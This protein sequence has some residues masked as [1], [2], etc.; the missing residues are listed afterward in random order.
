[1]ASA[2]P[3]RNAVEQGIRDMRAR[4]EA[5]GPAPHPAIAAERE[6]TLALTSAAMGY[7]GDCR[8]KRISDDDFGGGFTTALGN[9]IASI[10][11]TL[12]RG[13]T[14][15]ATMLVGTF[16]RGAF[17]QAMRRVLNQDPADWNEV[18]VATPEP[19]PNRERDMDWGW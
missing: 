13:Q 3:H 17:E 14:P 8:D 1:M 18:S 19:H 9:V 11:D 6:L 10:S 16:T 4:Y 12:T 5:M 15:V 7:L 2:T